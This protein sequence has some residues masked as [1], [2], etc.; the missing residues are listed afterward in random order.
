MLLLEC[1]N[2]TIYTNTTNVGG[3]NSEVVKD[4]KTCNFISYFLQSIKVGDELTGPLVV[5]YL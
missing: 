2:I 3:Y 5:K 4:Q 1:Y